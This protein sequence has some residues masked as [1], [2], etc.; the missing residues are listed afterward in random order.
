MTLL[1]SSLAFSAGFEKSV[2][3][4]GHWAPLAGAATSAIT[5]AESLVFNP[6]GLAASR[7]L[8]LSLNLD[9]TFPKFSGPLTG[10]DT[11][12]DSKR[13][14]AFPYSVVFSMSPLEHWGFG[15]GTYA[16]GG[17]KAI[18]E[19]VDFGKIGANTSSS[20]ADVKADVS[21]MEVAVGTAYEVIDGLRI[22]ASYRIVHVSAALASASLPATAASA[23]STVLLDNLGATRYN[24]FKLGLQYAP[25][26]KGWGFGIDWR[27]EVG[28]TASGTSSGTITSPAGGGQQ[29]VTGGDAQVSNIFPQ[30]FNV[31]GHWEFLPKETIFAQ[32]TW[33]EYFKDQSLDIS[34]NLVL[35][36]SPYLGTSSGRT[37][38]IPSIFQNWRNMHNLRLGYE[39]GALETWAFRVG[40]VLTTQVTP[41]GSA[42][43]TFS[44]P[45][46]GHTLLLGVGKDILGP[47]LQVD[48]GIEYSFA[49]GSVTAADQPGTGTSTGDYKSN[50]FA[51]H[52]GTTLRI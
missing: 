11:S 20:I 42:R 12:L 51:I 23:M 5:G 6:A 44:S 48:G 26:E 36:S 32:Y 18:Y 37:T 10:N 25:S 8:E 7:G 50:D 27:T 49:S 40:Y 22:G 1:A 13:S 9:P 30:Q 46:L 45:G 31:G 29:A 33:T 2:F 24:G 35:P 16:S 47:A 39:C 4:S 41:N 17:T 14:S 19:G 28:F 15:I 34:G 52:L 38:A 43:P 3:T 21:M